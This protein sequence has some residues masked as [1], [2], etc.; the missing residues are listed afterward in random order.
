MDEYE[1]MLF[2]GAK[3]TTAGKR[4]LPKGTEPRKKHNTQSAQDIIDSIV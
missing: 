4:A 2:Q 1:E 3:E